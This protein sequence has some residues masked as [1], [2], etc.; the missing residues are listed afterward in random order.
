MAHAIVGSRAFQFNG[1]D[2]RITTLGVA[3]HVASMLVWGVIFTALART[4]RGWMLA[5]AAL[6]FAA[7]ACVVD[8]GV[9]P[10][11]LRP[12]FETTLSRAE[13]SVVYLVLA[14]AL[15]FGVKLSRAPVDIG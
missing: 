14:I 2:I 1:F 13:V 6:A 5:G 8:Y 11:R 3:L 4:L 12:G 9:V 15:A 7:V 10:E